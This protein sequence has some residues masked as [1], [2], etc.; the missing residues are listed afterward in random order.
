MSMAFDIFGRIFC[1]AGFFSLENLR[2]LARH[3]LDACLPDSNLARELFSLTQWLEGTM[4]QFQNATPT[5]PLA[6]TLIGVEFPM[7]SLQSADLAAGS[8]PYPRSP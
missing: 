1:D 8:Y 2:E 6:S 4:A 3:G 7:E 5:F